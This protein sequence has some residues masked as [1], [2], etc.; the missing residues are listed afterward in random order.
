MEKTKIK[1]PV[2]DVDFFLG[3]D[4]HKKTSYITIKDRESEIVKKGGV[5]TS[6]GQRQLVFPV[7]LSRNVTIEFDCI[8]DK[9]QPL[10]G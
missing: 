10:N 2:D 9:F 5:I 4:H 8:R 1:A 3:I 7:A 6:S